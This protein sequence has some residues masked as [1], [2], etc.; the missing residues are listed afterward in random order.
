MPATDKLEATRVLISA[1]ELKIRVAELAAEI[2]RDYGGKPVTAICILKGGVVFFSD[3]I[4]GL[5]MPLKCEFI[6]TSSY[7]DGTKSSGEVK[8]TNDTNEPLEGKNVIVFE[9]IV[10]TGLTLSYIVKLLKARKPASLKVA[11]LLFKPHALK[12]ECKPDYCGFSI[13]NEFVVGYGLDYA[14][15]YRGLPYIGVLGG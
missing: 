14:G 5:A 6:G 2:N 15:L 7:G 1:D 11:S 3:V 10:D 4:R 9:D 12:T 8:L 13:G